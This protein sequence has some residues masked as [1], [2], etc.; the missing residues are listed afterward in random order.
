MCAHDMMAIDRRGGL[1]LAS[2]NNV[3]RSPEARRAVFGA[4]YS[5]I[6]GQCKLP[7]ADPLE[8]LYTPIDRTPL[9]G[10]GLALPGTQVGPLLAGPG[11]DNETATR[12]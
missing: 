8:D 3:A 2:A 10:A 7:P 9:L 5:H 11:L 12:P 1:G 6:V 4:D